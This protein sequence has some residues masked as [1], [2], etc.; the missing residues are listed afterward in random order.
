MRAVVIGSGI[1]GIAVAIRLAAKGHQVQVFEANDYPG[2][3]LTVVEKD[4]FRWDA[5]PSLFTMPHY[6]DELFR[7]AGREPQE[8]FNYE[9]LKIACEYFWEDGTHLTGHSDPQKFA[10]EVE[11]QLGIDGTPVRQ[12]FRKAAFK[13]EMTKGVFLERSLHRF[14]TYTS[15]DF[16]K[17]I[18]NIWRLHLLPNMDRVNR[19]ALEHPKLVQLFNRY[20]TYNGSNPYA[21]PGVLNLIPHFEHNVGAAFPQGG[22]HA[23]TMSLYH[24]A[25]DIGV[26]FN[27]GEPVDRIVTQ[28]GRAT[29]I[30]I[31]GKAVSADIVVSNMDVVP[32]YRH[33]MKDQKAPERVLRHERSSSALIFYWGIKRQFPQMDLHNIFFSDDY[34]TEFA[35]I[36]E[37][38]DVYH[39]PTVYIHIS[40][41]MEPADAPDGMEN[42]FVMINVPG[43]Q[44]QDWDGI[45]AQARSRIIEKLSRMLKVDVAALIVTEDRLEPRTIESRTSSYT[46]ALYGASS[47]SRM[48]AF[49]RHAN[50]SRK[51]KNLYF[52]GGSVHPGG[53][54]PLCL[55]SARIVADMIKA[56]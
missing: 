20:A 54:I 13:Y 34:R 2:G 53:G 50:F 23:I 6:V 48:S 35:H 4:G 15:R 21:A 41:K 12:H 27:F 49:L 9:R 51:I 29:G 47:N 37:R 52:C 14:S 36:F 32:T 8:H 55:L 22:M 1:A 18:A 39:D 44:G 38:G 40:S 11:T 3:K 30:E 45:I 10:H 28:G 33:L 17:G 24:L 19:K 43:N 5:G 31:G 46:G 26:E 7:L 42:W 16:F 56:A 25:K